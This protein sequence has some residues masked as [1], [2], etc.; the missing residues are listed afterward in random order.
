MKP[1]LLQMHA[2]SWAC[3]FDNFVSAYRIVKTQ[4]VYT[5]TIEETG[6]F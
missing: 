5:R 1:T 6:K 2:T 4:T 3:S